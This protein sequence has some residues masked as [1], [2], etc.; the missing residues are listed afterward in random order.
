MGKVSV[1]I[2]MTYFERLPQ[3][4]NTL[5]SF[6]LHGY[7]EIEVI[8][9]DDVSQKQPLKNIN[10]NC[11]PFPVKVISMPDK[12]KYTNPCIPFNVG[13]G[14]ASGDIIIIQNAECIHLSN[15]V[16]HAQHNIAKG[17]YI[18]YSCYSI[19]R[20]KTEMLFAKKDWDISTIESFIDYS[21]KS[22]NNGDNGW[23]NHSRYRP[24]AFHFC[25]AITRGDLNFIG[26]FDPR[27]CDGIGF[28]D[29]EFIYRI[30]KNG[31]KVS[32]VDDFLVVHQWHYNLS[33]K[34]NYSKL[35]ARNHLIYKLVTTREIYCYPN[36]KN[37]LFRFIAIIMPVLIIVYL[38]F[39]KKSTT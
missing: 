25:S 16:G 38:L 7:K 22:K 32:I 1:S 17:D 12:K 19:N 39:R 26:G 24:C 37:I 2:V 27:Y 13:L 18:T 11:Y 8:L 36:S 35:L 30:N 29:N 14:V 6:I 9:V 3:L 31:L 10:F 23:Y 4:R 34:P 15:I 33:P 28:D 21:G 20:D 5:K